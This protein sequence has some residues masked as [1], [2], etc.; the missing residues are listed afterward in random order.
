M[1]GARRHLDKILVRGVGVLLSWSAMEHP[2]RWDTNIFR[3]QSMVDD[4]L[5][6]KLA[7]QQ[8]SCQIPWACG[9]PRL[10]NPGFQPYPQSRKNRKISVKRKLSV[11]EV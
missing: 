2:V 5:P 8:M 9:T 3:G 10:A 11:R 7:C 4:C 1:A 6:W